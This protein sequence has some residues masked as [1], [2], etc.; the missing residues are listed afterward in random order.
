MNAEI[1]RVPTTREGTKAWYDKISGYYDLVGIIE[2]RFKV[3]ALE[4]AGIKEGERVLEVGCGT[5][6][7]LERIARLVGESGKAYGLD[8]SPKML[9]VARGRLEKVGLMSRVE[10]VEGDATR[11]EFPNDMFDVV[12]ASFTL[13]LFDTPDI[14][15]LLTEIMRVLKPG[16]RFV[17]V[18]ISRERVDILIRAYEWVHD[19][20]PQYVDCRP[21]YVERSLKRAGF[22]IA[23]A[24]RVA[25][26]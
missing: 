13:E 5:G 16:G 10:L 4:M 19:R 17:D 1:K 2:N 8:L 21:I 14:P 6:W 9:D 24:K 7:A 26:G 25:L 22:R 11:M 23:S 20:L 18:S 12:F 3:P 15:V